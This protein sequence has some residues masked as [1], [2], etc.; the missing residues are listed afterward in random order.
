MRHGILAQ[1]GRSVDCWWVH[2]A[3]ILHISSLR[4]TPSCGMV[5]IVGERSCPFHN[6]GMLLSL[7]G[8]SC[9]SKW[10]LA[11]MSRRTDWPVS[12][13]RCVDGVEVEGP[14]S[15]FRLELLH[16]DMGRWFFFNVG[17]FY[18]E[19]SIGRGPVV[20][21]WKWGGRDEESFSVGSEWFWLFLDCSF[22]GFFIH[23]LRFPI[24]SF[25]IA[26]FSLTSWIFNELLLPNCG[27]VERRWE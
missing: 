22:I 27:S 13:W 19:A 26:K 6:D 15:S 20:G 10:G 14:W 1:V 7:I 23:F 25:W 18:F 4:A 9:S 5:V 12:S 24:C 8:R 17:V 3:T 11:H 2:F 16:R 21:L